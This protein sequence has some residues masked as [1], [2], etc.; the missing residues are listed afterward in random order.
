MTAADSST[1]LSACLSDYDCLSLVTRGELS[2]IVVTHPHFS[3]RIL[4]QG[5]QMLS[6]C[7]TGD[8]D[9]LWLSPTAEY[10][11]EV[12]VRGGIPICW[13]WF[14]DAAKNPD[15]VRQFIF[16]LQPPA[17]GLARLREWTLT[18]VTES[19]DQ[20]QLTLTLT[21]KETKGW[22]S[23]ASVSL[24]ITM[25]ADALRL[26]LSTTALADTLSLT[27]ALHTYFPTSD[28]KK[29]QVRGL[30]GFTY[31]DAL[32]EW[33]QKT[34]TGD[35][36]FKEETDRVYQCPESLSLITPEHTATL[37]SNSR[38]C[39]VWNPWRKKSKKL[40]QFPDKAYLKMFCVET[41]NAL[42]DAVTL[43]KGETATLE[44][45]LKRT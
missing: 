31:T 44:M 6:F 5:A 2:E 4:T 12:S 25:T 18:Q 41:A 14:G 45:M 17:H 28:I 37:S 20:V 11:K 15:N 19:A 29:T 27:Q 36:I 7:P 10:R 1:N 42:D 16:P 39:I 26:R 30:D 32:D 38:S 13:P 34:Q 21:V 3:A 23:S 40:S 9:W 43:Q 8:S 33:K 24:E 22:F 35:V